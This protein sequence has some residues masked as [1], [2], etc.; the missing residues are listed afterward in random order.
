MMLETPLIKNPEP[1][2]PVGSP[3]GPNI[4]NSF[5]LQSVDSRYQHHHEYADHSPQPV[6]ERPGSN[7]Q[8]EGM[9]DWHYGTRIF[10][11]TVSW[12]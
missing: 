3:E 12:G 8:N 9:Q 10:K 5:R 7:W 4:H 11:N 6:K 1:E 2:A